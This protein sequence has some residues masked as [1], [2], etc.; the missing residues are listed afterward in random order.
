MVYNNAI[1]VK[2][3]GGRDMEFI[4]GKDDNFKRLFES[5]HTAIANRSAEI[6][7]TGSFEL[8]ENR[9]LFNNTKGLATYLLFPF[10]SGIDFNDTEALWIALQRYMEYANLPTLFDKTYTTQIIRLEYID[11]S[12]F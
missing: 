6:I 7:H 5:A 9:P 12:T 3:P 4:E 8:E 1:I 10:M 11:P 2:I